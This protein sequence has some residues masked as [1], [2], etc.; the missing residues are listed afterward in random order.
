MIGKN[1]NLK[2]KNIDYLIDMLVETQKENGVEPTMHEALYDPDTNE[3]INRFKR[4]KLEAQG[5]DLSKYGLKTKEKKSKSE[6][7][8]I[9]RGVFVY[10]EDDLF[11][12]TEGETIQ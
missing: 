8:N 4:K 1:L 9:E 11:D 3:R 6:I 5:V 10:S 7:S 2:G 12:E